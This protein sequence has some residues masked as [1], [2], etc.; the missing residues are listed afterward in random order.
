M[1]V[2]SKLLKEEL[3]GAQ[4]YFGRENR[5]VYCDIIEKEIAAKTRLIVETERLVALAPYA[6]R[7]AYET[8]ILPKK[9]HHRFEDAD[10]DT[11]VGL[12]EIL[13]ELLR[14]INLI[15][16]NPPYN[17][18]LHTFSFDQG[19]AD[20][21]YHWHLELLPIVGRVAGF[22]WGAGFFINPVPPEDAATRLKEA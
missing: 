20:G 22:E 1:P 15:L 16:D 3:H 21:Y 11:I 17:L 13:K 4:N 6:S 19:T 9:H 7:F 18:M 5:C 2:V 14:K 8:L 12:A 10:D